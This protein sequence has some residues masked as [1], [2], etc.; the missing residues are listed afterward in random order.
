MQLR[1]EAEMDAVEIIYL[2]TVARYRALTLNPRVIRFCS[3]PPSGS[4]MLFIFTASTIYLAQR[5]VYFVA[6][7]G[8]LMLL[9]QWE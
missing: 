3:G 6:V 5:S 4:L 7:M 1:V 9:S 8:S 2:A